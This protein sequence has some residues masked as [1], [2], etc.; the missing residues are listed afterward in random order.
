MY[1]PAIDGIRA[2]AVLAYPKRIKDNL[3]P[4]EKTILKA[5]TH[6]LKGEV[7]Q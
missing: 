7:S 3:T 5:L 2:I 6:Q 4:S 1:I